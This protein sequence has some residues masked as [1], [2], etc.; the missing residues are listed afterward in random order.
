M[1]NGFEDYNGEKFV[2]PTENGYKIGE[3]RWV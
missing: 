3:K 2:Y 1:K